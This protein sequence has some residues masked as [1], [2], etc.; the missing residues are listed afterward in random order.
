L[1][2]IAVKTTLTRDALTDACET[3][4]SVRRVCAYAGVA[5]KP[6]FGV[7]FFEPGIWQQDALCKRVGEVVADFEDGA[8]QVGELP[9]GPDVIAV[10]GHSG[11]VLDPSE[12]MSRR[13]RVRGF[14][15][16]G[17]VIFLNSLQ[18]AVALARGANAAEFEAFAAGIQM[19]ALAGS[20]YVRA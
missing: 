9:S 13:S 2:A 12:A 6:W 5:G 18:D 8:E 7:L 4:H 17:A 11:F 19:P 10:L 20:P 16:D 3:L 15:G 1:G 14:E